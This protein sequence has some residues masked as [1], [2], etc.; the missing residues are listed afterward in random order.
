[1]V[2]LWFT[3]LLGQ[4]ATVS[5]LGRAQSGQSRFRAVSWRIANAL[6]ISWYFVGDDDQNRVKDEPKL[7]QNL[8][9]ENLNENQRRAV[10]WKDGPLLVLA[11]PGS[12][13]TGVLTMRIAHLIE[14]DEALPR[15][16]YVHE[17]GCGRNAGAGG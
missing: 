12:G 13:K 15:W 17:Q 4:L 10:E 2:E 16:P 1:M 11:G 6:G 5:L 7:K 14:Q 3:G 9:F 8:T